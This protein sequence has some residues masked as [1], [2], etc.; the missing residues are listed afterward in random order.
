MNVT[1]CMNNLLHGRRF[2]LQKRI[3]TQLIARDGWEVLGPGVV[4]GRLAGS[5][6]RRDRNRRFESGAN[7]LLLDFII[8]ETPESSHI[9]LPRTKPNAADCGPQ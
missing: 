6:R 2:H 4:A 7:E 1:S 9:A 8:Y 5:G 3:A